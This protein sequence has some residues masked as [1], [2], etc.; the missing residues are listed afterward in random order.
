MPWA[1]GAFHAGN[2][3]V[4]GGCWDHHE[5]DYGLDH[6]PSFPTFST[7]KFQ[8]INAVPSIWRIF[9]RL[10]ANYDQLISAVYPVAGKF[11]SGDPPGGKAI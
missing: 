11:Q 9:Q 2:G 4:A 6:E 3:W 10:K 7:R 5:N 1:T 8:E